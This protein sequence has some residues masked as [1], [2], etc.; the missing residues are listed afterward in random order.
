MTRSCARRSFAAETIFIALVIC[1][2]LRT[3]RMRRRMSIRLGIGRRGLL[4]LGKEAR[5]E[6]LDRV[7]QLR[8][9]RVVESLLL[10]N[11]RP[12]SG[13]RV[14]DEHVEILLEFA[15]AL[16]RQVVQESACTGVHSYHLFF[17]RQ[18]LELRLLQKLHQTPAAIQLGLRGFI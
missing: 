14:V 3:D 16:Y 4:L 1:C 5:L 15:A 10:A 17:D 8:A 6:L 11:L 18:W 2:V 7:L 9:Q 12:D 13:M